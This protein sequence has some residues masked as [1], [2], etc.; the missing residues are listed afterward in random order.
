MTSFFLFD[1]KQYSSEIEKF[2]VASHDLLFITG[3]VETQNNN[4]NLLSTGLLLQSTKL[5]S[6]RWI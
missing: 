5:A 4:N 2:E 1:C 6:G 3:P